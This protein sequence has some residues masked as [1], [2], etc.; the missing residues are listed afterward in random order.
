MKDKEDEKEEK[1][2]N[3][4]Y[5]IV[6][7]RGNENSKPITFNELKI[8]YEQNHNSVCKIIKGDKSFGTG[9]LCKIPFES[10]LN[11]LPVLITCNHVLSNEDLEDGKQIKLIFDDKNIKTLFIDKSRKIYKSNADDYDITMIEIKNNDGFNPYNM[12]EI[13]YDIKKEENLNDKY[14]NESIYMIH[15]P[16]G[17]NASLSIGAIQRIDSRNFIIEHLCSTDYG[18]SGAPILDL[19]TYKV[20]GIHKGKAKN[21]NFNCG[22][23]VRKPIKA[24]YNEVYS[25]LSKSPSQAI[26]PQEITNWNNKSDYDNNIPKNEI[27]LK[28]KVFKKDINNIVYF[29]DNTNY[30]CYTTKQ[31]HY[32][33]YLNELNESNTKV[34]INDKEIKY[35]KYFTPKKE[36]IYDIKI[37][38]NIKMKDISFIF[39]D[40]F[41]IL[42]IDFSSFDTSY[43]TNMRSMFYDCKQLKNINFNSFCTRNA[44]DMSFM[45]YRCTK[46][47]NL[48]IS[49]FN[50]EKVKH[51]KDMFLDCD[52]LRTIR[53]NKDSFNTLKERLKLLSNI[54]IDIK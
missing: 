31:K 32:H 25:S 43:S 15:Y 54:N 8:I 19:N 28:I 48:D 21:D 23:I 18:S 33:D 51:M 3:R 24:F 53:V 29:L 40:C 13:D 41:N 34:Y 5:E 46:L 50:I 12:L 27:Y 14:Q 17:Q 7:Q 36:G 52:N 6:D 44:C 26:I 22:V 4:F 10:D 11:L 38:I 2:S 45:F 37:V 16:K 47:D 1:K 35:K 42:S 30:I 39:A 9:F 20:I 49:S